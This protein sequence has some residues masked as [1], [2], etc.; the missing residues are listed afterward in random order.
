M[1]A[2]RFLRWQ[3]HARPAADLPAVAALPSPQPGT[4]VAVRALSGT[5]VASPSPLPAVQ[6]ADLRAALEHHLDA[7]AVDM[8]LAVAVGATFLARQRQQQSSAAFLEAAWR[9]AWAEGSPVLPA[10]SWRHRVGLSGPPEY[11]PGPDGAA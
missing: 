2:P 6:V 9:R 1:S 7:T 10:T 4:D 3:P 5:V 8:V 11:R